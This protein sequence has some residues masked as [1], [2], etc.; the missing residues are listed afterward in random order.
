[1]GETPSKNPSHV[2]L[3]SQTAALIGIAQ[4]PPVQQHF[5]ADRSGTRPTNQVFPP[6][7]SPPTLPR[8]SI[9]LIGVSV[10][11][12]SPLKGI[13]HLCLTPYPACLIA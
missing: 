4:L 10:I 9:P 6:V 7:A 5:Y 13:S 12:F 11:P 2:S 8:V 3:H 1:M